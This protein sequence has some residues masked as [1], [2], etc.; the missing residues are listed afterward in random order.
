MSYDKKSTIRAPVFMNSLNEFRKRD[1]SKEEGKD[2]ESIQSST[3]PDPIHH[4]GKC[5]S[6]KMLST[7]VQETYVENTSCK[8][9]FISEVLPK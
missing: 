7:Y 1:Q 4:M 6:H 5:K 8:L 3:K 2:E 9:G